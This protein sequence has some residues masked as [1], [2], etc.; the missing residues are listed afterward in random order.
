VFSFSIQADTSISIAMVAAFICG[1]L[2]A[3]ITFRLLFR[4][5]YVLNIGSD[6]IYTLLLNIVLLYISIIFMQILIE[7]LII[8]IL[9]AKVSVN[10]FTFFVNLIYRQYMIGKGIEETNYDKNS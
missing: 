1:N 2:T 4:V 8:N 3:V 5:K 7:E 10:A 9:F 6:L